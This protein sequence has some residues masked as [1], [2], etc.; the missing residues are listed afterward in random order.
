MS[1]NAIAL[2]IGAIDSKAPIRLSTVGFASNGAGSALPTGY[3][4]GVITG[5]ITAETNVSCVFWGGRSGFSISQITLINDDGGL[6]W[7]L[8]EPIKGRTIE[9]KTGETADK[10]E[11]WA[12]DFYGTVEGIDFTD[13]LRPKLSIANGAAAFE[14]PFQPLTYS[15]VNSAIDGKPKPLSF[16]LPLNV[17][18]PLI[19]PVALEYD[20][21]ATVLLVR[22]NGAELTP[23]I[24]WTQASGVVTL[25][26][27]P[28]GKITAD[29][30]GSV[31]AINEF[32]DL[33][34]DQAGLSGHAGG[35]D[36]LDTLGYTYGYWSQ[37]TPV[38]CA[39][40]LN[41]LMDSH[42][43]WW[44]V[45]NTN[46]LR[47]GQLKAPGTPVLAIGPDDFAQ[48]TLPGARQDQMPGF[49]KIAALQ[50]N[51]FV[52]NTSEI[53]TVLTSP[54]YLQIALDLQADYRKRVIGTTAGS[55]P[56]DQDRETNDYDGARVT[57]KSTGIGTLLVIE[58]EA[59]AEA[60]RWLALRDV[61]RSFYDIT[62]ILSLA[63]IRALEI[64][65]T[66][67]VTAPLNAPGIVPARKFNLDATD[68]LVI[69]F[70]KTINSNTIKLRL[71]G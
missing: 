12:L 58:A 70:T 8:Y 16:G 63:D 37:E 40:V 7:L 57:T 19:D 43:G 1:E 28:V 23:T 14:K 66:V 62:V 33:I 27:S 64:G 67:T 39:Q 71:W 29:L 50:K 65:D 3:F 53:A 46:K 41:L 68:L 47:I 17:P 30:D 34:I 59:Q 21:G 25:L 4:E 22:D 56:T 35:Y 52:H 44:W 10:W 69:G 11:D 32:T 5:D 49:S 20:C 2:I 45:D 9:I 55:P 60:D 38:T 26:Q 51:Y 36:G 18:P 15:G 13:A 61:R 54:V 42:A 31:Y 6:D 24:Q 48:D